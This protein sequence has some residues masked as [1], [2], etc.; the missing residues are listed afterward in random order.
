MCHGKNFPGE[1]ILVLKSSGTGVPPYAPFPFFWFQ[2]PAVSLGL[3]I[4]NGGF[5]IA[6]GCGA[7][8][9]HHKKKGEYRT[10]THD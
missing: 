5:F 2:L 4:L 3:K 7:V 1:S 9:G 10:I 6:R 8:S